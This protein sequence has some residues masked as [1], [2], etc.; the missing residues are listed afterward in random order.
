MI[1][2]CQFIYWQRPQDACVQLAEQTTNPSMARTK[3]CQKIGHVILGLTFFLQ[4][5]IFHNNRQ[6]GRTLLKL[7]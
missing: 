1:T 3:I 7:N 4:P 5:C 2:I 6:P